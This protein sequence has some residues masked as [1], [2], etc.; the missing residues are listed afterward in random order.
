MDTDTREVSAIRIDLDD[1]EVELVRTA[2]STA[3]V[4][5]TGQPERTMSLESRDLGDLLAEELRRLDAD[6]TYA[7]AL[8][9][10]TGESS[11]SDRSA[12]RTHVWH[13]PTE[14]SDPDPALTVA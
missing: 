11:L 9:A 10:A 1:G 13:D 12:V 4:R 6:E 2:G 3:T 14:E 7:E 8:A 5:R